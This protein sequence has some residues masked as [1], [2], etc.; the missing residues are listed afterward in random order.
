M[1]NRRSATDKLLSNGSDDSA[2][3]T[4]INEAT[5]QYVRSYLVC[6]TDRCSRLPWASW[7]MITR[8]LLAQLITLFLFRQ[9]LV[10]FA[11]AVLGFGNKVCAFHKRT[12][13]CWVDVQ[14]LW[15]RIELHHGRVVALAVGTSPGFVSIW[16]RRIFP[17]HVLM[18]GSRLLSKGCAFHDGM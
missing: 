13:L 10:T 8:N 15:G 5:V 3:V 1:Q 9:Y 11:A 2:S 4:V 18:C 14:S 6:K 16:D 12:L 7:I 17:C